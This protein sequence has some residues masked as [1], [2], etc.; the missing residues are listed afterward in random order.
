MACTDHAAPAKG[1]Y[2]VTA[3]S[4]HTHAA[5]I[6]LRSWLEAFMGPVPYDEG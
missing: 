4:R 6:L 5:S 2:N 1:A 3:A